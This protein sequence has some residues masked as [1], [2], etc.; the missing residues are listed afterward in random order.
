MMKGSDIGI[1]EKK[2]KLFNELERFTSTDRESIESYYHRFSKLMNDFKRNK[3]FPEKI[4]SNLKFL[5]N[6]QPEWRRHVTI[7]HQTKDLRTADYTQLYDFLKYNQKEVDELRAERLGKTHDLLALMA[8]SNYLVFYQDQPS[9]STYIQQPLPNNN[10]NPQPSFNMDFMQQPMPNPEDIS[11]PTTAMNMALALMAKAFKLN[12]STPTNNNQRISSNPRNRQI[13]QPG[14][15]M[16]QDRQMQMV[17]GNGGN[18]FRQYVRNQNGYNAVQNV[19]NQVVQNAIQNLGAEG[20]VGGNNGNQIRCYNCRGLGH[21]TGNCTTRPRRRDD[22]YL[23]TQLLIAQKEE[24]GFQLQAKEFD[25]MVAAG[26]LDEIEE[27][28][29][30][31]ILM[32]N[33][34]KASTSGFSL[35]KLPSMTQT[36]QLSNVIYD[37]P[38]VEQNG[39]TKVNLVNQN[40]KASNAEL[41]TELARYKNQEKCFEISQDKYDKLERCYQQFVYQEQCLTKKINALHLSS[42]K[43]ITV[44][45]EE[46]SNINKQLSIEKSTVSSLLEEK[47]KLKSDFKIREDELLNKQSIQTMHMLSPK[48]DSF[49]HTEQKMALEKRDPPVVH[50]SEETLQLAQESH[51]SLDK[52]K[53][54]EREIDRLLRAVVSQET[55]SVVQT[56][57]VVDTSNLQTELDCTKECFENYIIQKENEYAKL[58]NEWHTKCKECKH[59]KISYDKSYNDMQQMIERLQAQLGDL[60]GKSKDTSCVSDT[61][62][63][64]S[65]KLENGNVELEFQVY[66]QKDKIKGT[67]VNTLFVKQSILGKPPSSSK[68]N[69]YS[70][71]PLPKTSVLPK[72]DKTHDLS[73]PVT[74]NSLPAPQES[75]VMKDVKVITPG[76]FRINPSKTSR[77]DKFM[78]DNKARARIRTNPTT[79]SQ[80][81]VITKKKVNSDS[82]GLSST[83]V[84]NTT[85]TRRPQ[86][87]S[88]TKNDRVSSVS[89]SSCSKNKEIEVEEHHRNLLLSKKM[90]H[91]SSECNNIKLTIRNV[92]SKAV[93]AMC[94]QCLITANHD[95]CVLNYV[96]DTNSCGMKQ[97]PKVWKPKNVGSKERLA[98]PKPRKP[99]SCLRWSP[100]G[101][102]FDLTGKIIESRN[103]ESLSDYSNGDNAYLGCLKYMTGNLKLLVN[104]IWKFLGTVR[105]GNDHVATILSFSD[106][107]WGNILI[108]RVYFVEGLGHNLFSVGQFCDA[109]LEVAFRRNTCFVRN[110]EGVDLL[111]GNYTTNLYTINL[112]EMASASPICLMARA[113]STKSWLW[114]QR[115][116]H[117]NFDTINDLARNDLVTGL[118]KFKYHKEHLY[119][120]CEQRKSKRASHL[121]KPV[122]NSK[123]RSK[124]EAPKVI[125]TFLKRITVLLQAIVIIVRTDNV[126]RRNRTLVEAARTMLIFSRAPL[127]LWAKAIATACY[128]QNCSIIHRRFNKT[129]YELINGRKPDISFLYV[130]RALYY[131]K[132]DHEDIGK[133]GAKGDIGFFIGYSANSCAYRVYNRRTKKIMET[134]NVTFDEL[135]AMAFD[136]SSSKPKL[137]S[138]TSR[139]ISSGLDLTCTSSII[140]T[141][142]PTEGDLDLLFEAI[143]DDSLGGQ[144]S[145]A[146]KLLH[147]LKHLKFLRIQRHLQQ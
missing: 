107:Q 29:A 40:L 136:Q 93:C 8:T 69:L 25:F 41:T 32:A 48:P 103:I 139:Q 43:Q 110:L 24:A 134:M 65:Q 142:K 124:D 111:K 62:D 84:N 44:L 30:N 52:Q 6:L 140:T 26:D 22:V 126:E 67:S 131:P 94:K 19:G 12:Y 83:G 75:K 76:M 38:C 45:N 132:N 17:R 82:N 70:V 86:P 80:P 122:L 141:Q 21:L 98:S 1:Q 89:K 61:L 130:F 115:L 14:M 16:G 34:Q 7:V 108:T 15:N 53:T 144:P 9:P 101:R 54:L 68:K 20:N 4:A 11:D 127:F 79:V 116:S 36:N 114:H 120:S 112:H 28:D 5:N 59:G 129:P 50:D 125:K 133:L 49:Y 147:M 51:E 72:V 104:F 121:P 58:W 78:T 90:K 57:S 2:A 71:T 105:F 42:G 77:E 135:S 92:K 23:Q 87:R 113:T 85:K 88:N 91:M 73:K 143:Y 27:V 10:Y 46:I 106:L 100:T 64:L 138:M 99:R 96:N 74:S 66:E 56:N 118:P 119:P 18:K 137:Q 95:A 146:P 123:T 13:P 109:D 117:L 35:T 39:S 60:K 31:Y 128:T 47:K 33:L 102:I 3:H 63:P 37:V 55:M 145:A 97:K 81:Q